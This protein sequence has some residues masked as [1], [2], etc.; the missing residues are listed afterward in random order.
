M[1]RDEGMCLKAGCDDFIS[2]PIDTQLLL[3][4]IVK[5]QR[6]GRTSHSVS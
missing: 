5:W 3:R 2:K 4:K 6:A 1:Q